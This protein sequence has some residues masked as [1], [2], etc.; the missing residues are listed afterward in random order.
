MKE[1]LACSLSQHQIIAY[2]AIFRCHDELNK[3]RV[4]ARL[5]NVIRGSRWVT[6][7]VSSCPWRIETMP[8]KSRL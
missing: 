2:Q 5:K 7:V 4:K 3:E 8:M 6:P 1:M